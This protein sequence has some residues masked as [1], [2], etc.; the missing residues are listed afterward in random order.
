MARM[1]TKAYLLE[2][3]AAVGYDGA[4]FTATEISSFRIDQT[5][6]RW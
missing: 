5:C 1:K 2:I 4:V 3:R 6:Y